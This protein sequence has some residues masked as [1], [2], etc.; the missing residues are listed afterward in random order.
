MKKKTR[1]LVT[2]G[3]PTIQT[4]NLCRKLDVHALLWAC[5]K[6]NPFKPAVANVGSQV[7]TNDHLRERRLPSTQAFPALRER[8]GYWET[9]LDHDDPQILLEAAVVS[10][11]NSYLDLMGENALAGDQENFITTITHAA[12]EWAKECF[13]SANEN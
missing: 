8:I 11:L 2:I 9:T 12:H 1:Y 13:N 10:A 4:I 5:A 6:S 3:N 7:L